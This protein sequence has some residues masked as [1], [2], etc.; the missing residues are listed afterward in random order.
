MPRAILVEKD[1]R[2]YRAG[3]AEL[4]DRRLPPGQTMVIGTAGNTAMLRVMA[5]ERGGVT[6]GAGEVL[7]TGAAGGIVAAC[8]SAGGMSLPETV[9]PF[10]LRGVILAGIDGVV[11]PGPERLEARRRL[12]RDLDPAKLDGLTTEAALSEAV[13]TAG[14][15]IAG[16]VRGRLAVPV[17]REAA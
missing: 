15:L 13:P 2:G 8:G 11:C 3:L 12:A 7:V 16:G 9:A 4:D 6:T 17:S 1:E 10:V 14:R 5:L